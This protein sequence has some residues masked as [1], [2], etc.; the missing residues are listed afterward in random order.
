MLPQANI[1]ADTPMGA[2]LIGGGATFPRV[3]PR[4]GEDRRDIGICTDGN[5]V[6]NEARA[7]WG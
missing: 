7:S 6:T 1:T 4:R 5:K 3:A 2:N